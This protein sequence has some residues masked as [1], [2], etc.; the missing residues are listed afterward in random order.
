[1]GKAVL[2]SRRV[3]GD[4]PDVKFV[5]PVRTGMD[6]AKYSRWTYDQG[7]SVELADGSWHAIITAGSW[8]IQ[9]GHRNV[10]GVN[11]IDIT[12]VHICMQI[13]ARGITFW[14]V[15]TGRHLRM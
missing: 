5:V 7:L 14:R 10:D 3:V 4:P 9:Y 11:G 13:V 6:W 8:G 15:P 12:Q 1:M 2:I